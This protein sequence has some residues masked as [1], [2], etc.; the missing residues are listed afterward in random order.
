MRQLE[1][2]I[3]KAYLKNGAV[4]SFEG[5]DYLVTPYNQ[6][7]NNHRQFEDQCQDVTFSLNP[8]A[9]VIPLIKGVILDSIL[10]FCRKS[11]R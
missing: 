7:P 2:H 3:E 9:F 11:K 6:D 8:F 4:V 5:S 1:E 10:Y